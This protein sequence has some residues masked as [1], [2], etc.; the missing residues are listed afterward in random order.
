MRLPRPYIDVRTRLAVVTRQLREKGIAAWG[1]F[2]DKTLSDRLR[3]GLRLLFGDRKVHLHHRPALCNREVVPKSWWNNPIGPLR[4][5][6]DANDPEYLVYLPADD[7]DIETRVRGQHGD[8][9]DLAKRRKRKR[10]EKKAARRKVMAVGYFLANKRKRLR[11]RMRSRG[12]DKTR[13]RTF[14]GEVVPR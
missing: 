10:A 4:Y 11:K 14:R 6:P 13:T 3:T 1:S 5:I 7:H 12:F 8:Y 2:D 9:S